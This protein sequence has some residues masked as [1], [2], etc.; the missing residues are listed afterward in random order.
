MSK[1][2]ILVTG[3][4]GKTG[5]PVVEQLL[6]RGYPVRAFAQAISSFGFRETSIRMPQPLV[7]FAFQNS[8]RCYV[9]VTTVAIEQLLHKLCL[10]VYRFRPP[11]RIGNTMAVA[12]WFDVNSHTESVAFGRSP[13]LDRAAA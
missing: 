4:T 9:L 5:K 6:D 12:C 13:Q 11:L 2:L 8:I 3:A 1:P 7:H 10:D